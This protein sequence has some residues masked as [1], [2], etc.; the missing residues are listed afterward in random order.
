MKHAIHE[1]FHAT[2][3]L[4]ELPNDQLVF[5][6][7]KK[8]HNIFLKV[9]YVLLVIVVRVIADNNVGARNDVL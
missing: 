8:V 3:D 6:E 5:Q 1:K 9:M 7:I 2:S 4:A